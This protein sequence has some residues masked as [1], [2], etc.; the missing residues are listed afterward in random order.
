M[1][2]LSLQ[3][4]A[5][6]GT[7]LAL[8]LVQAWGLPNRV[9]KLQIVFDA[10]GLPPRVQLEFYADPGVEPLT[11]MAQDFMLVPCIDVAAPVAEGG[12]RAAA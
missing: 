12:E 5:D 2:D 7:A 6:R 10:S 9:T 8:A 1:G 11:T 3:E 4:C